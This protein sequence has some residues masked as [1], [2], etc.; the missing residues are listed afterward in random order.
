MKNISE[1]LAKFAPATPSCSDVDAEIK[2]YQ[3]AIEN[4]KS[5]FGEIVDESVFD[6]DTLDQIANVLETQQVS[7]AYQ[8]TIADHLKSVAEKV[9]AAAS[10]KLIEQLKYHPNYDIGQLVEAAK[11]PEPEPEKPVEQ[12]TA[13]EAADLFAK[14]LVKLFRQ[15]SENNEVIKTSV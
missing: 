15:L 4:G 14:L 2:L 10:A 11:Q 12:C 3:M 5:I 7:D 13:T 1:I 6:Q 9:E 8:R